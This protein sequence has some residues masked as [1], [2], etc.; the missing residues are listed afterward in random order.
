MT[1]T[2]AT[3]IFMLKVNH[4]LLPAVDLQHGKAARQLTPRPRRALVSRIF[5]SDPSV[6]EMFVQQSFLFLP[7]Q[8]GP[9]RA[10]GRAHGLAVLH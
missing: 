6:G 1:Q 9:E 7:G 10:I 4:D 2:S 5:L 3:H 8:V